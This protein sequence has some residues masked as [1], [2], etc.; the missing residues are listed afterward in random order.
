MKTFGYYLKEIRR[1]LAVYAGTVF[2]FALVGYLYE[3]TRDAVG[4]AL[5]LSAVILLVCTALDLAR[6]LKRERRIEEIRRNLPY[7]DP[8]L[9][10]ADTLAERE[11]QEMLTELLRKR[12]EEKNDAAERRQESM[13][14]YSLWG[15]QIKTPIA[16]MRL[17]LQEEERERQGKDSFL[18]EMDKELFR[19]EQYVEMVMTYVRIGDISKDL[20]LQWYSLDKLI[21]QAVRKY[22]RLFILQKLK[23]NYQ[24]SDRIVLTD[25]KWLS[26]I[27][28]QLL[29]NA[30]KYTKEG[31]ISIRVSEGKEHELTLMIQDTGIGIYAEDL[32]RVFERGF[33]GYT[34]REH[35]KSTG[36]GLYLCKQVADKLGHSI[37]IE[38]EP[39]VGTTVFL[40]LGRVPVQ[41]E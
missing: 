32:P 24:E 13:D 29:S 2:I 19:T 21:K 40:G 28:E 7:A 9:P 31:E 3:V 15:H 6:Y 35:K 23:L 4:Y 20:V 5:L 34:G 36:I 39:G 11:Y 17:L 14:Y 38:S 33:T 22:S 16:A 10:G 41:A 27:L 12:S 26:F 25:E 37:W 1:P 18:R 8:M 30:L